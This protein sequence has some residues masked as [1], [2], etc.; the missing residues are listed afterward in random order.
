MYENIEIDCKIR[1]VN[2]QNQ[3]SEWNYTCSDV[4]QFNVQTYFDRSN[5]EFSKHLIG[6]LKAFDIEKQNNLPLSSVFN[7]TIQS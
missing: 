4:S 3:V 7:I 2:V 1:L 6:E 5:R